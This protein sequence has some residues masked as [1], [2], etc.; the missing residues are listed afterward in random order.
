MNKVKIVCTWGDGPDLMLIVGTKLAP[1]QGAVGT[2]DL[3]TEEAKL[4]HTELDMAIRLATEAERSWL[5]MHE[6]E[7]E[8]EAEVKAS[9]DFAVTV[10]AH[11][12]F[13]VYKYCSTREEAEVN[14]NFLE[15]SMPG[16]KIEVKPVK[17][18]EGNGRPKP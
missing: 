13:W 9:K 17:M 3:T 1:H 7:A 2:L 4:L 5:A 18:E 12:E 14:R 8:V 11:E 6:K 10:K 16:A 15:K